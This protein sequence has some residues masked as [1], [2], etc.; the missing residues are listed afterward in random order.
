MYCQSTYEA[1]CRIHSKATKAMRRRHS[2]EQPLATASHSRPDRPTTYAGRSPWEQQQVPASRSRPS[3]PATH[4]SRSPPT[5]T[6]R[7]QN[8]LLTPPTYHTCTK[9]GAPCT[10]PPH[11]DY[12]DKEHNY[13]K[14]PAPSLPRRKTVAGDTRYGMEL[15]GNGVGPRHPPGKN[16]SRCNI[17]PPCETDATPRPDADLGVG[18]GPFER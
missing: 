5:R 7:R 8:L 18:P 15:T 10:K 4:A 9:A 1:A 14:S 2:L 3:R 16:D 13:D 11:I 6:E 17:C 12:L